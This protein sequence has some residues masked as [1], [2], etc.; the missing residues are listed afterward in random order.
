MQLNASTLES[1]DT[2]PLLRI[3]ITPNNAAAI[4]ITATTPIIRVVSI[5][6]CCS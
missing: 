3:F 2:Y 1:H 6:D 5:D 4:T